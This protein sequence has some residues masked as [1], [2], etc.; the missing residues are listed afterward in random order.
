M[1]K[2]ALPTFQN[3]T[4]SVKKQVKLLMIPEGEWHYITVKKFPAL[5]RGITSDIMVINIV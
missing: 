2:Y 1:K 4:Q 3:I 5:L